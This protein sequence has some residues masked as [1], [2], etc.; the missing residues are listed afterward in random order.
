MGAHA[1]LRSFFESVDKEMKR[2]RAHTLE[3]DFTHLYFMNSSC[4]SIF[5]ALISRLVAT[6]EAA[7]YKVFFRR[8]AN[9]AWQKRSLQALCSFAPEHVSSD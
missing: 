2:L 6:P 8:N 5:S 3:L 7:R 4:L 9:L 1:A